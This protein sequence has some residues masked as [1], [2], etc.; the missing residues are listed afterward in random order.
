MKTPQKV[1]G[2]AHFSE[3]ALAN[4]GNLD[5]GGG[6]AILL[7]SLQRQMAL[8]QGFQIPER[9]ARALHR[10]PPWV[11]ASYVRRTVVSAL[12]KMEPIEALVIS[13]QKL[14]VQDHEKKKRARMNP[15]V[16]L[17]EASAMFRPRN[18][19]V[20]ARNGLRNAQ[21]D[22]D[23]LLEVASKLSRSS[24]SALEALVDFP[25]DGPQSQAHTFGRILRLLVKVAGRCGAKAL[26]APMVARNGA[27]RIRDVLQCLAPRTFGV[28]SILGPM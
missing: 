20:L 28:E 16:E 17:I 10:P 13:A 11:V 7:E 12:E 15:V 9:Q 19:D 1:C 21:K 4:S 5:S 6:L 25:Q 2:A 24:H 26:L 27:A 8:A 18:H 3:A 14:H 22:L 23:F